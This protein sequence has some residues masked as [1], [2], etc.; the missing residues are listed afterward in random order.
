VRKLFKANLKENMDKS[1]F[2][3]RLMKLYVYLTKNL[4]V[5]ENMK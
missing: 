4:L 5:S 3:F 2:H 1:F